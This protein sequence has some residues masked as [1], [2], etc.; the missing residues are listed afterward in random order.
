MLVS[1]NQELQGKQ[2]LYLGVFLVIA[3]PGDTD[4]GRNPTVFQ[5]GKKGTVFVLGCFVL[6]S[7][8]LFYYL[9]TEFIKAGKK[10]LSKWLHRLL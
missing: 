6:F 3:N 7:F 1:F 2:K 10:G 5:G 4:L 8:I 9:G